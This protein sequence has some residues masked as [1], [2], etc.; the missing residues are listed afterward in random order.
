MN[1]AFSEAIAAA[2]SGNIEL[3][4]DG[5]RPECRLAEGCGCERELRAEPMFILFIASFKRLDMGS[6]FTKRHV[7]KKMFYFPVVPGLTFVEISGR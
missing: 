3:M 1:L 6:V 5:S 2:A 4:A 7:S